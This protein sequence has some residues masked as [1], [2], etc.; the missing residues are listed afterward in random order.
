MNVIQLAILKFLPDILPELKRQRVVANNRMGHTST[1]G[2]HYGLR[3]MGY[4]KASH[5]E[6]KARRK[7]AAQSRKINRRKK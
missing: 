4:T 1:R 3:G 5:E 7:M 6:S 2:R